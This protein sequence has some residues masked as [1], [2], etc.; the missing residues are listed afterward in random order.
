MRSKFLL[1]NFMIS[2]LWFLAMQV[3]AQGG[4]LPLNGSVN[5]T[6]ASSTTTDTWDLTTT[7]DGLVRLTF[8]STGASA[9]DMLVA[10]YDNNGTTLLGGPLESYS[11]STVNL[12]VDGLAAGTYHVKITPYN[13][14]SVVGTYTLSDSLFTPTQPNDVEPNNSRATALTLSV[15]SSATGHV[16]YYYNNYRDTADWYKVTTNADGLL[17]VNLSTAHSSTYSTN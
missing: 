4:T 12:P 7:G 15:N 13:T 6:L 14:G 3:N 9:A 16:G 17:K 10:I 8:H 5:G 2:S 1:I 11:N